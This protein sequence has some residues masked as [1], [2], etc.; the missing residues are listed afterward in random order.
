MTSPTACLKK[1]VV[2]SKGRTAQ[3][4]PPQPSKKGS[5]VTSGKTSSDVPSSEQKCG[6]VFNRLISDNHSADS[7]VG[8]KVNSFGLLPDGRL[9]S[10][11]ISP[12]VNAP[13][14]TS[15]PSNERS[16]RDVLR[17]SNTCIVR[18]VVVDSRGQQIVDQTNILSNLH[19]SNI[20]TKEQCHP[21]VNKLSPEFNRLCSDVRPQM[22]DE[23]RGIMRFSSV[24]QSGYEDEQFLASDQWRKTRRTE[25]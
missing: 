1:D 23:V 11:F 8:E 22:C 20:N 19:Q 2:E 25:M 9:V 3:G 18:P 13:R 21:T 15:L 10:G 24:V 12:D 6:M 5:L 4:V 16:L 14:P 7:V 17:T